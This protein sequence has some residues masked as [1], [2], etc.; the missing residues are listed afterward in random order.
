MADYLV[1]EC[2]AESLSGIEVRASRGAVEL[3]RTV[4]LDAPEPSKNWD[5]DPAHAA[6]L[7]HKLRAN[8]GI[9]TSKVVLLIPREAIVT[10]QLDLPDVPDDELPELVRF[11]AAV[12]SA[13]PVETLS[14]DFVT[15]PPGLHPRRRV[16]AFTHDRMRIIEWQR[17]L[18]IEGMELAGV[19]VSPIALAEFADR[20]RTV[21]DDRTRLLVSQRGNRVELSLVDS[22]TVVFSHGTRLFEGTG[23]THVQPL[24]AELMRSV[25]SLGQLHPGVEIGQVTYVPEGEPDEAVLGLLEQR[26]PDQVTTLR[27]TRMLSEA[28]HLAGNP[29]AALVGAA[30]SF[31]TPH[32]Q[33]LDLVNPRRPAPKPDTLRQKLIYGGTAASLVLIF[34]LA[35]WWR[36]VWAR[37][38]EIETL[39]DKVATLATNLEKGK[40]QLA[41][42]KAVDKWLTS[43]APPIQSLVAFQQTL[44][45]TDR[46]YFSDLK[47]EPDPKAGRPRITG[48]AHARTRDDKESFEQGLRDR[49]YDV[50]PRV[51][52]DSRKDP[53]YPVAFT[54]DIGMP[55]PPP[56]NARAA[57]ATEIP[58]APAS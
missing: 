33:R 24:Q 23:S 2:G 48:T 56:K 11:Q 5:H 14:L 1:V 10:R 8:S 29:S 22:R 7:L 38:A 57:S 3:I 55:A 36:A 44:P 54:L 49:G 6:G 52:A 9:S 46:L 26:F 31:G 58:S 32:V 35:M 20:T 34:S 12:R 40:P 28:A 17:A 16:L 53:D 27:G 43:V 50:Q 21:A 47:L 19:L 45:G 41:E 18:Q 39:T 42:A 37:D 51:A 15:L 13:T 4:H 30:L 25:V